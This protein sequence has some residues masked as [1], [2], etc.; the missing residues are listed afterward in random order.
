MCTLGSCMVPTVILFYSYLL[1]RHLEGWLW[2]ET[3]LR[4]KVV[5]FTTKTLNF[6]HTLQCIYFKSDL[7][8]EYTF[9][10]TSIATTENIPNIKASSWKSV[11]SKL[12]VP[13]LLHSFHLSQK[14]HFM[15]VSACSLFFLDH[16]KLVLRMEFYIF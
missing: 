4:I 10:E 14:G 16:A 11:P 9:S 3:Y 2:R 15:S 12:A 13:V 8:I 6:K 5:V 1:I 7:I